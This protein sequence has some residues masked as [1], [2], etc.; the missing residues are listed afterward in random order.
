[1][2]RNTEIT[3]AAP[4]ASRVSSG[5]ADRMEHSWQEN[6]GIQAIRTC[7]RVSFKAMYMISLLWHVV[8]CID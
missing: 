8:E 5:R 2:H 1:M 7:R 3:E 6:A 4:T